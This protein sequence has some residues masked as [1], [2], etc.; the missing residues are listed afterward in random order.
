MYASV[1]LRSSNT[2]PGIYIKHNIQRQRNTHTHTHILGPI[3]PCL[4]H[5]WT[6]NTSTKRERVY[7]YVHASVLTQQARIMALAEP[8][9]RYSV[10]ADAV[11]LGKPF[12]TLSIAAMFGAFL[13]AHYSYPRA[14]YLCLAFNTYHTHWNMRYIIISPITRITIKCY[15]TWHFCNTNQVKC[16]KFRNHKNLESC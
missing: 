4:T 2:K 16:S 3:K 7:I 1:N 8:E 10:D 9:M 14:A 5:I 6:R 11:T 13:T 12:S 15:L